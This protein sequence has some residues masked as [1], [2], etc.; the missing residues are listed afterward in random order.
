MHIMINLCKFQIK[1]TTKVLRNILSNIAAEQRAKVVYEYLHRQIN[2]K[3]V[4]ETIDFLLNREEAHNT[5]C[6]EASF[7]IVLLLLSGKIFR[8]LNTIN[9]PPLAF[10]K[11]FYPHWQRLIENPK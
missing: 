7:M 9:Y 5:T 2:D 6:R 4:R 8:A 3:G 10:P 11:A 1:L